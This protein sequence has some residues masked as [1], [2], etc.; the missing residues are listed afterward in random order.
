MQLLGK[1]LGDPNKKELKLIQPLIDEINELEADIEQLSD[2]ELAARTGEFRARLALHLKGGLVLE[3]ELLQLFREVINA[4]EPLAE[5]C[6]AEQLR[7]SLTEHRQEIEHRR[8]P[9]YLLRDHLQDTLSGCFEKSY[10]S[11][12]P[13]LHTLRVN[14]AMDLAEETQQ[15]PDEA[16]NPGQATLALL[17]KA[18]PVLN[19]IDDDLLDEAFRKA[20]PTFEEARKA[21]A[22]KEEGADERLE[23]LLGNILRRLQSEIVALRAD[24]MDELLP[25]LV[26]RYKEGKTLDEL[27]PEAFAIVREAGKRVIGM[28]HYD[29]QLI[30]GIVLHQGKIAEMKTGEGKTLVATLPC[31]LNALTG[32]GVHV[33]TVNDYL[34][35]RDAEWMGKI[36]RALG[37]TVGVI[38]NAVQPQTPERRIA[39]L[40]DITYG[41]NNEFGFDYLRDNMVSSLDQTVQR[42]LNFAIVDEVDNILIDEARTPLIISGAGQESTDMYASFARWATRLKAEEDYT[43]EE[44][45]RTVMLTDSGI[46]RLEQM[47]GVKN[48]YE[49]NSDLPRYMENA[50][51]AQVIFQRD[52]DYIV[53]NGEVIIVD[54]FTGRQMPGRRYS[55]GLHQAI[56][57][58]EGVTVQRENHTLATITFQNFFRLYNKLAGMTGTAITEAEELNKIYNLDVVA[59]PTN[60]PMIRVDQADYIYRTAEG[61]YNA[62]AEEIKVRN[63]QGQPVLVGTTSVE[64]S[65]YLSRKLEMQGIAHNVLNAKHHERE[66][67]IVAQA[68]RSCAVTIATNMAGRG[69]DI[70]LGGNPEGYFESILRKYAEHIDFIR[71]MAETT[72]EERAEKEEAIQQYIDNMTTGEKEEIFATKKRECEEDHARVVELGGLYIIGTERH[73]SRRIDL[74]LRGRSGRQGDPGES[75]FFLSLEDEL[76]RRFGGERVSRFM[77]M[78]GM[79]DEIPLENKMVSRLIE[80]SQTRVEGYNFDIRKNVVEYDDV[81]AKQREV[82]YTDR[83]AVLERADMHAR[84]LEMVRNEITRIVHTHIPGNMVDEEGQ[85]DELFNLLETW[86]TI[87]DEVLPENIHAIRKSDLTKSLVDAF[88][89]HYEACGDQLKQLAAD[90]LGQQIP[91]IGDIERAFTLQVLDRLWMDHIDALDVMRASIGFRSIGQRDPLVEFKNEAYLMFENLKAQIQH[92]IVDQLLRLTKNGI[93]ITLKAPE[94]PRRK[95]QRPLRTNADAI[96]QASGQTKTD[97][98]DLPRPTSRR[99]GTSGRQNGQRAASSASPRAS[100]RIGRN[101]PCPCGSGKKYKKCHGA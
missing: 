14:R 39:Y 83:R 91:T 90:N 1:M 10:D 50:I 77:E 30:G 51:K 41:T 62:V 42:E 73:E 68:G 84:V 72:A 3:D 32:R 31:Y 28:R 2:E 5:R 48:I 69:T 45:T 56:E 98:R 99:Q 97:E 85:L 22:N 19:E 92:Y 75:R 34:A 58:K 65:E 79:G 89:R 74:Q 61:K 52:K 33:V 25:A 9:E 67:Q 76:M 86:M 66:A 81:I 55:E 64:I 20:W 18:E 26:K 46:T 47:A 13:V 54:E 95:N 23:A 96:A 100:S 11:L 88:S 59:I 43:V 17:K 87:P 78:A 57:A 94:P 37:L 93:T 38:V 36:H 7:A 12:S 40:A 4:V 101:D 24:Q 44:K 80:Q 6:S 63:E 8:D 15:W 27:L 60:K 82:I 53:K 71:E 49:E 21:V 35:R 16:K 29:V 70:L